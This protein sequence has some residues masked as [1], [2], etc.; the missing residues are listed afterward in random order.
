M[1]EYAKPEPLDPNT[2]VAQ[3]TQS[4]SDDYPYDKPTSYGQPSAWERISDGLDVM[5]SNA[6]QGM[7]EDG[8]DAL[9]LEMDSLKQD[10]RGS[11]DA[12][13][14]TTDQMGPADLFVLLTRLDPDFAAETFAPEDEDEM[15][16]IYSTWADRMSGQEE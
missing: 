15:Q 1:P 11:F 9:E 5:Q 10:F 16:G 14:E 8:M 3:K 2:R 12:A 13:R 4:R 6:P 7:G